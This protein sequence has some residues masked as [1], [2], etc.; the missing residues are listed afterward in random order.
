MNSF[1]ISAFSV[2]AALLISIQSAQAVEATES[3]TCE[4]TQSPDFT[5]TTELD[6]QG[7][8]QKLTIDMEGEVH[9][10]YSLA[11]ASEF[12]VIA[13]FATEADVQK[14]DLLRILLGHAK[15]SAK[16]SYFIVHSLTGK[17]KGAN[18]DEIMD[19]LSDDL[20]GTLILEA[21]DQSHVVLGRS[22]VVGWGGYFA[23]CR[24]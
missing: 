7:V 14:H 11:V 21:R 17:G 8:M 4:S 18:L 1:V 12:D 16:P 13:H 9:D 19:Y 2:V 23:N 20:S 15:P 22:M 5:A 10:L 3:F 6:S 24:P